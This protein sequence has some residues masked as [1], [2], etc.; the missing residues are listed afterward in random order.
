[1]PAACTTGQQEVLRDGGPQQGHSSGAPAVARKQPGWSSRIPLPVHLSVCL[2]SC[3][4][5]PL[6]S[7]NPLSGQDQGEYLQFLQRSNEE[8]LK[9]EER[10]HRF[11]AEKH[12]GLVQSLTYLMNKV[13]WSSTAACICLFFPFCSPSPPPSPA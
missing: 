4:S 6:L 12:C 13:G 7:L 2:P 11:L 10:R 9:E 5:E 1:M 3:L 8:A